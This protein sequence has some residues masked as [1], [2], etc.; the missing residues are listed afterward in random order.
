MAQMY[1]FNSE[2]FADH[3]DEKIKEIEYELNL[4][5]QQM[6]VYRSKKIDVVLNEKVHGRAFKH[7]SNCAVVREVL[8]NSLT[9]A[10]I[11]FEK[12]KDINNFEFIKES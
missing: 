2:K 12:A 1:Y 10:R 6:N 9:G 11:L 7:H 3:A 5:K 4:V 8:H